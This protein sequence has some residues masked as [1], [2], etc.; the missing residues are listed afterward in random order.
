MQSV[1]AAGVMAA[2]TEVTSWTDRKISHS[3]ITTPK[4]PLYV[5]FIV[6]AM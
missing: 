2:I 5:D 4:G 6:I 1:I 3:P